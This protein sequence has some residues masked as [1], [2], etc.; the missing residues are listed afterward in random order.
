[1]RDV[2]SPPQIAGLSLAGPLG[3][4]GFGTVFLARQDRL[5]RDVAV[6]VDNRV[7]QTDRDRDRFLREA[8]AAARLSGHPNVVNVYDAG[9]TADGRPYIVMELCTG[10]SL[11]DVLSQRGPLPFDEVV[12]MGAKLADALA[13]A[14]QVGILHRDIK[15][16]NILVNSFGAVKLADFG[17]AA[18]LDAHAESTVTVGALSPY[19]AAP[20]VFAQAAPTAAGDI[21]SLAATI[22]TLASGSRPRDIPWPAQ[23]LD[24]L[25]TAL[26]APV[27]P[28]PN[29]PNALNAA[30]LNA[31]HPDAAR[32]TSTAAQLRDELSGLRPIRPMPRV[33]TDRAKTARIAVAV[34][35]VPVL[36]AAG[37][38]GRG[39]FGHGKAQG[40]G[41]NSPT[42]T[43]ASSTAP[44]IPA[45]L[46]NCADSDA[47]GLC[48]VDKCF[49]GIVNIADLDVRATPMD[50]DAK[51]NWQAFAGTLLPDSEAEMTLTEM[52]ALPEVRRACS[53]E[54]MAARTKPGKDT[55]GWDIEPLPVKAR[56]QS[57]AHLFCLAKPEGTQPA[58][59]AFVSG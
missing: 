49:G 45:G 59:S 55:G 46:A 53:K 44:A 24:S 42:T 41:A 29:A 14:H 26:R 37:F 25:I 22:Y 40:G 13:H 1:M 7:L 35:A 31:L 38:F 12:E 43:T 48:A 18:I 16:A 8:R 2:P 54:S 4:G 10:G 58:G 3:Q 28:V 34:V 39:L 57:K 50:C 32:R 15:P 56:G 47:H 21:Y 5:H 51:H 27:Q 11:S 19:Y 30:L 6:K 17:L 33:A 9:V 23:S 36:V 20:E 52:A